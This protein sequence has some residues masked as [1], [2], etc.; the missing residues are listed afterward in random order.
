[1][2]R[3]ARLHRRRQRAGP[4]G[5]LAGMDAAVANGYVNAAH[6]TSGQTIGGTVEAGASVAVY[7]NGTQ[8][9][10]AVAD[11]LE[12]AWS[13]PGRGSGATVRRTATPS[14]PRPTRPATP[15]RWGAALQLFT[16]DTSALA[17]AGRAERIGAV[18]DRLRQ[19]RP[20]HC[21]WPGRSVERSPRPDL[22]RHLRQRD[23]GRD[24]Y[25]RRLWRPGPTQVGALARRLGATG[26]TPSPPSTP[27]ATPA[28]WARRSPSRSTPAHRPSRAAPAD[29]AVSEHGHRQR[30]PRHRGP[31][32]QRDGRSRR[33]G[34]RV[35]Q[36]NPRSG[37]RRVADG[38]GA[39]SYQ[40]GAL[41]DGSSA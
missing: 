3:G 16:V 13:Y 12:G 2:G 20:R 40:V 4:A 10:T 1:M 15:A 18:A 24:G 7:D 39:W 34:R 28:R 22:G 31:D 5:R 41:A 30:G 35:R 21:R 37:P 38:A 26:C 33:F 14:L 9:G 11:G 17:P 23:P 25:G 32:D 36:R 29:A 19:R 8:V 6:D 27:P